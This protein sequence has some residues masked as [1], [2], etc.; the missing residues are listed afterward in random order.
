[1]APAAK[2]KPTRASPSSSSSSTPAP[3]A[4]APSVSKQTKRKREAPTN[5]ST[6]PAPASAPPAA[7]STAAAT[8]KHKQQR[9]KSQLHLDSHDHQI[10]LEDEGDHDDDDDDD[11]QE[12]EE[13]PEIDLE[14]SDDEADSLVRGAATQS[15]NGQ[16]DEDDKDEEDDDEDGESIELEDSQAEDDE[17]GESIELEDSQAE[18]DGDDDDEE[19][20]NSSD[21]DNGD[22][23]SDEEDARAEEF[24]ARDSASQTLIDEELNKMV[25]RATV[26]PD[27]SGVQLNRIGIDSRLAARAFGDDRNPDGSAKAQFKRS[28][29]TGEMKRVYPEI[30]PEYDSDS[31]TEDAPNRIGNV[32]LEWYDDLPHIGYDVNG[33]KV[34]KP[35]TK[36]ELD[37]FLATVDGDGEGWLSAKDETT[38]KDVRLTDEELDII[39][40]LQNAEIPDDAY[41]P[42]EDQVEWFTGEGKEMV[43]PLSGRPEPKRR[44]VPSKWEHKKVMKIVRA[45]RAGRIVPQ[46]PKATKPRFYNIWSNDDEERAAHPMHMPA[47][48]MPLPGH[49]ESYNPPAEYLFNDEERREWEAA[50]PEDRK[51]NF[52]P[53]KHKALR[54]VP[55]YAN[56]VRER[57]D[58]CL[59]LYMA[60]RMTRKRIDL[61]DPESLVPKLPSPKE[62]RPFPTVTGVVYPHPEGVRVRCLSVDPKG[63]WLLTG[64]DD[65]RVRMWDLAV[66][67][68]TA[69]WDI[70]EG[71]AKSERGPVYSVEWCPNKQYSLFAATTN[72]RITLVAPPQCHA[73]TAT[74]TASP[75][76]LYATAAYQPI[77]LASAAAVKEGE[78][79]AVKAPVK[80][81][82][83]SESERKRG[84][85]V[86]V[87]L[88][89][90][91]SS[92]P[93]SVA[94][95]VKGDYFATV[96]PEANAGSTAV[97][98]HQITKHRSQAPFRRAAKGSAVQKVLFHP[99]K[100]LLLVATQRYVRIYDLMAQA[101]TKTLM[102]GFK[103]ISSLDI[104]PGGD[105]VIVG[106]YDKKV[107]WFDLDLS[108][109]PF[110]TMRYHQRAI[111]SVAYH[112]RYPLFAS[113]S[114]DGTVQVFHGTVYN[115][116]DRNALIVPLK[117]LRGHEVRNGLGVLQGTWH[118]SLPWLF[119][120]G[121]DGQAR[122]W[123]P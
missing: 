113:A 30:E 29:L 16:Q 103:W 2:Q 67:R 76:F 71:L 54:L 12:A 102:T 98:I 50:E 10:Q 35:A 117:V 59:D 33:R 28:A 81:T 65:G 23:D 37:K 13:F 104:H 18:D 79:P 115:E 92:T 60:P 44:F 119:T 57:L 56:F 26:K 40:R 96:C 72:G 58:R 95:H 46:A 93:K 101:L 97:L 69:S 49:E 74:A 89:S 11:D 6:T 4:A 34:M 70:N 123:I 32:P 19:G 82:R 27:E 84:V 43:M 14:H 39:R 36:D 75:S 118:P 53:A 110:K 122:V 120:A 31:S 63:A 41:D 61:T 15:R 68:C 87:A 3:S 116:F 64:A 38:G 62:L 107:A 105:N 80:W 1:M 99:T 78:A 21:I 7:S 83:P 52:M 73:A 90:S 106:S 111:R 88:T 108:T 114:D 121:A 66:G 91:H 112:R 47:P 109:R 20:Y 5:H 22:W 100:P 86:H 25:K 45:I 9:D 17:D 55:G 77:E 51:L 8:T 24:L 42:Y 94:W 85:A 48:K